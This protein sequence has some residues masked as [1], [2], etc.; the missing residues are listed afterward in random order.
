MGG[1]G[2]LLAIAITGIIAITLWVLLNMLLFFYFARKLGILEVSLEDETQGLQLTGHKLLQSSEDCSMGDSRCVNTKFS[3][4]A[5][6]IWVMWDLLSANIDYGWFTG[7]I[8][9]SPL[10][11]DKQ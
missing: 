3:E 10:F 9:H 6:Q 7:V 2:R 5:K 11:S 1:N 8:Y 4:V